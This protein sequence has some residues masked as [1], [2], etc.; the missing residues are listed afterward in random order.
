MIATPLK[1]RGL[2]EADKNKTRQEML[3]TIN[4]S[5]EQ[6]NATIE[7]NNVQAQSFGKSADVSR[8]TTEAKIA[9]L[10]SDQLAS[11]TKEYADQK[12]TVDKLD[13]Q[14]KSLNSE[15][16]ETTVSANTSGIMHVLTDKTNPKYLA[17]GTNIAEIYPDMSQNPAINVE[18]AVPADEVV[19]VKKRQKIR[20]RVNERISKPIL[21][22]GVISNVDTSA[23]NTKNGNVFK[24][25]AQVRASSLEYAQLKYGTVGQVTVITGE[26]TWFNYVKDNLTK[27]E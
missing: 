26:K 2:P 4:Q 19:G 11:V 18:F 12:E 9:S 21:I 24:V 6:L 23:T 14:L 15:I 16:S 10:K 22:N 13:A 3:M 27:D 5:I 1:L 25:V 8:L 20:F 17:K 7:N